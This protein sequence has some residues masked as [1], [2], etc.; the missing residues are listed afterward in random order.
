MILKWCNSG[1][2]IFEDLLERIT[3]ALSS[4]VGMK[5]SLLG[6]RRTVV[7]SAIS[8]EGNHIELTPAR[9][10]VT[11]EANAWYQFTCASESLC[12]NS[13]RH[14]VVL[15]AFFVLSLD[16]ASCTFDI[17]LGCLSMTRVQ[18]HAVILSW[19]LTPLWISQHWNL[20]L[21]ILRARRRGQ[22]Q[23]TSIDFILLAPLVSDLCLT[24][25]FFFFFYCYHANSAQSWTDLHSAGL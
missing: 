14:C 4:V 9:W 7:V 8:S 19:S 10:F 6:L 1:T 21:H 18:T 23:W 13:R 3:H 11:N 17:W 5:G 12:V 16:D 2:D 15:A 25:F 20:T 24:C 22:F